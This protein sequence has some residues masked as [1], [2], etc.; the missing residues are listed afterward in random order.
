MKTFIAF[1]AVVAAQEGPNGRI[2]LP[3][4]SKAGTG[5]CAGQPCLYA[6]YPAEHDE[7]LGGDCWCDEACNY[8][9]DCCDDMAYQCYNGKDDLCPSTT[10][11]TQS[12]SVW[13]PGAEVTCEMTNADCLAV[14]CSAS[15][16]DATFKADLFHT[17]LENDGSFMEQLQSGH[18]SISCNGKTLSE[19]DQ[20]GY[21][22]N[23]DGVNINWNYAACGVTPSMNADEQIEYS[24]SCSSPGNAPGYETIEFY[25]DTSVSASCTYNPYVNVDADGFWVNQEDVDAAGEASGSL[26]EC[27]DCNFYADAAR[28]NKIGSDNIVNMGENIYGSVNAKCAGNGL[29]YK[30]SKVKFCDVSGGTGQCLDVIRGGHGKNIVNAAVSK[31]KKNDFSVNQKFRFLSFGFEDLSNQNEVEASCR[32]RMYIDDPQSRTIMDDEP[33]EEGYGGVDY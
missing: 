8:Y 3:A 33:A 6:P 9:N 13:T 28:E 17:N 19:G 2:K 4:G 25:V 7:P 27:F 20:C 18:R 15:G 31:P 11:Y 24:V 30:L 21:T 32:I 29:L 10:C 12:P 1:T 23:A 26:K 14:S 5:S 16:I 22:V